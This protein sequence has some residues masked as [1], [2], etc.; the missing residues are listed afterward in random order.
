MSE[1]EK[2]RILIDYIINKIHSCPFDDEADI[3]FEEECVGLGEIGCGKTL[4]SSGLGHCW[5]G[6]RKTEGQGYPQKRMDRADRR[7]LQEL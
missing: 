1:K 7:G 3:D 2:I 4:Y 6:N 5:C